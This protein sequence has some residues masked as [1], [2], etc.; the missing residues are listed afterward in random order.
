MYDSN[1][2]N[3]LIDEYIV[4]LMSDYTSIQQDIDET[5]IKAA[6]NIAQTQYI[7]KIIGKEAFAR[8]IDVDESIEADVELKRLVIPAWCF[9]TYYTLLTAF[10]GNYTDSGYD[11]ENEAENNNESRTTA[12]YI[13]SIGR[14]FLQEVIDF[15][16]AEKPSEQID[17]RKIVPTWRAMGGEEN[18]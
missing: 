17:E 15:L 5:R 4:N 6:A 1:L 7:K 3:G 12:N 2:E 9:Y 14:D 16:D 8:I 11:R 10:N 18:R 13:K